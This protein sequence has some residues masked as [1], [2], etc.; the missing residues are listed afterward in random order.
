MWTV[1][2]Q[3]CYCIILDF[4]KTHKF[5]SF[6]LKILHSYG[7]LNIDYPATD[8]KKGCFYTRPTPHQAYVMGQKI[9]M[10]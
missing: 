8:H 10:M 4:K 5:T 1:A 2:I 9:D 3:Q 7:Y 6:N